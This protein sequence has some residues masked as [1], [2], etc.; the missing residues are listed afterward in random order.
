MGAG[1]RDSWRIWNGHVYTAVFKM[2]N[3]QDIAQGT[4]LHVMQNGRGG[5]FVGRPR[6][7]VYVWLGAFAVHLEL[8]HTVC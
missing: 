5:E 8:S 4:L 1:G 7:H 3:R 2:D 6:L